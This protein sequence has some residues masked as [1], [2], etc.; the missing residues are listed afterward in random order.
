MERNIEGACNDEDPEFLHDF[1]LAE[2]QTQCLLDRYSSVFPEA[3]LK[4]I[5][6]DFK[7]IEKIFLEFHK[8]F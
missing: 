2:R 3:G 1:L 8:F 7:W 5:R 6:E 4:R